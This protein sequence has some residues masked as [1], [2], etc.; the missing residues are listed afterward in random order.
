VMKARQYEQL[1]EIIADTLAED[2]ATNSAD[3]HRTL[4]VVAM[5]LGARNQN[6]D[7]DKFLEASTLHKDFQNAK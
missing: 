5:R 2:W 4:K 3:A 6:M 7:F 1:A